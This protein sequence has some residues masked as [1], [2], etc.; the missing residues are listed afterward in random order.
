MNSADKNNSLKE[1]EEATGGDQ[2]CQ[3]C[4]A[5][6]AKG[7][8][9]GCLNCDN[10]KSF[11]RYCCLVKFNKIECVDGK[12]RCDLTKKKGGVCRKCRLI[13]CFRVGMRPVDKEHL[14]FALKFVGGLKEGSYENV[15]DPPPPVGELTDKDTNNL[16]LFQQSHINNY[17]NSFKEESTKHANN[18]MI[19]RM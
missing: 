10:C 3:V 19:M 6:K 16:S 15:D 12:E 11:F 2:V 8:R 13:K 18:K 7:Y 4:E 1:D 5:N 9:Y 17:E 14:K